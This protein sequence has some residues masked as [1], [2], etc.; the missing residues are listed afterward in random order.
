MLRLA[1]AALAVLLPLG[2]LRAQT[3]S[4]PG[5]R[6]GAEAGLPLPGLSADELAF[7][8]SARARFAALVSVSGTL[9]GEPDAGLGPR[10][11]LNSCG[12]CHAYPAV[13]GASPPFNPEIEMAHLDGATNSIPAFLTLSGPVLVPR[14]LRN[15]DGTPDGRV[16]PMFT[17]AGRVDAPGCRAVQPDF[18]TAQKTGNLALRIPP[19]L[20]GLGL[21]ENVPDLNL[22][23]AFAA[24]GPLKASLGITGQFNTEGGGIARFGWKAQT[25]SLLEFAGEA[26]NVEIGVSNELYPGKAP[27]GLGCAAGGSPE[28]RTNLSFA[29]GSG[30]PASDYASN[31]V[32]FAAFARMTAPPAPAAPTATSVR[33]KQ[34]F[35]AA[36]CQACHIPAQTTGASSMTGQ[37]NVT[38]FPYSDFA[39]HSMGTGLADG[40]AQGL[41]TGSQFRTAPLWG[42]GPRLFFLHDGRTGDLLQA[43]LAHDSPQSEASGAIAR[44]KAMPAA[45]QQAL[46]VFL[47]S[48]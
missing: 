21:V 43:I 20:F 48:L 16:H 28:D 18:V 3:V 25:R 45:D 40:I 15:P 32:N 13:G 35:M 39:V 46:L 44:F 14:F 17:V 27:G 29:S 8:A 4:D 2:T 6:R 42:T 36:G 26:E 38:F 1:I 11:D 24:Q 30:S 12:G 19:A 41:A 47:R 9:P 23:A 37:S 31:I 10:F 34:A 33:G 22:L 7:F 5:P